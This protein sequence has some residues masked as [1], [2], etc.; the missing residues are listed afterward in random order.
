MITQSI[1]YISQVHTDINKWCNKQTNEGEETTL[2]YRRISNNFFGC[3]PIQEMVLKSPHS[4]KGGLPRVTRF[5][6]ARKRSR[7]SNLTVEKPGKPCLV[8]MIKIS[9]SWK[10]HVAWYDVVRIHLSGLPPKSPWPQSNSEKNVRQI[11]PGG[12]STEY[13]SK[14]TRSSK[15]KK[16]RETVTQW[17]RLRRYDD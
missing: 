7:G 16:A 5:L 14:L 2:S 3:S 9:K 15:T 11:H 6:R 1:K 8:Q 10:W 17:R 13:S 4:F 12:R